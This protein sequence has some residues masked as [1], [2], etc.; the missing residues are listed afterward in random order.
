MTATPPIRRRG[1]RRSSATIRELLIEAGLDIVRSEGLSSG[2]E[3]LTFK[4]VFEHL[5]A[6][7]VRLTHASVIRRVF[8]SQEAY[9]AEVL[10]VIA[11]SDSANIVTVA[12]RVVREVVGGVD[13]SSP[14]ARMQCLFDICRV[15]AN[16]A[17]ELA[18]GSPMWRAWIGVWTLAATGDPVAKA[19]LIVAMKSNYVRIAEDAIGHYEQV[20]AFLGL[21]IRSPFAVEHFA[22][23]ASSLIEG[24]LLR[25]LVDAEAMAEVSLPTGPDGAL[26]EWTP[27]S[28][29]LVAI[30]RSMFEF[31]PDWTAPAR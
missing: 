19:D 16:V 9:Q 25:A 5:E 10:R 30:A 31:D 3:H 18:Q 22:R 8:D 27:Q 17:S 21:R 29:G 13:L 12:E 24:C 7:G 2:A 1:P 6:Q 28:I 15:G 20:M 11:Q 26:L 4:R 14:E 23:A